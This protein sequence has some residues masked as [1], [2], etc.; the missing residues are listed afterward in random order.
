[1]AQE[2]DIYTRHIATPTDIDFA[3]VAELY[4]LKYKHAQTI[5][6][7][8]AAL[9]H[10]LAPQAGSTIVHVKSD[11]AANVELHGRMWSAVSQACAAANPA[12]PHDT[13]AA[14]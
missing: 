11:R 13:S 3:A 4:G 9:E 8:R 1:M 2:N 7:L 6:A 5:P 10:A 14:R 12:F